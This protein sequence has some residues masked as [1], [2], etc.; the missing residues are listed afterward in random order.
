MREQPENSMKDC[1]VWI[2]RVSPVWTA[3][4]EPV[5][6]LILT[7]SLNPQAPPLNS[8]QNQVLRAIL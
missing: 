1:K 7:L 3:D 5:P 4:L 6:I 8:S 2:M